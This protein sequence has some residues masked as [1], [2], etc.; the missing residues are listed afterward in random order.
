MMV[1]FNL[2]GVFPF[3]FFFCWLACIADDAKHDH[4]DSTKHTAECIADNGKSTSNDFASLKANV[5]QSNYEQWAFPCIKTVCNV[6]F[7]PSSAAH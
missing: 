7:F 6:A 2:T 5:Q 3:V 4:N 1:K